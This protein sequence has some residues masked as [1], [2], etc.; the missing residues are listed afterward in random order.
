[1]AGKTIL[2]PFEES[3]AAAAL[4]VYTKNLAPAMWRRYKMKRFYFSLAFALLSL[5]PLRAQ[6][7]AIVPGDN[8]IVEGVPKIPASLAET[9]GRY[10][11]Y[12]SSCPAG[13]HPA[14]RASARAGR[15]ADTAELQFVNNAG[16]ERY[17]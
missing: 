3:F 5:A 16:A 4:M 12:R 13:L 8:L 14:K 10:G 7:S 11:S 9:A 15:F 17:P 2:R 1:M 6:D